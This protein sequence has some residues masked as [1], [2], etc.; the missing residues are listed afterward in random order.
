MALSCGTTGSLRPAFLIIKNTPAWIVTL[1]VEK[2]YAF[3]LYMRIY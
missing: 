3:T 2:A 1:A